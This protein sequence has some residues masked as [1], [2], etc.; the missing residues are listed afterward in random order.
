MGGEGRGMELNGRVATSVLLPGEA[1]AEE[2]ADGLSILFTMTP[3]VRVSLNSWSGAPLGRLERVRQR[4]RRQV[5]GV[6]F[7]RRKLQ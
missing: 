2:I 1:L 6:T 4:R 7:S 5:V 3:E